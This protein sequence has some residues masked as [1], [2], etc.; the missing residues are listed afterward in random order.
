MGH[1]EANDP[2]EDHQ[3]QNVE[4]DCRSHAQESRH[5]EASPKGRGEIKIDDVKAVTRHTLALNRMPCNAGYST[6]NPSYKPVENGQVRVARQY[7]VV[8]IVTALLG[9][10][11]VVVTQVHAA[12]AKA[13]ARR[14][15]RQAAAYSAKVHAFDKRAVSVLARMPV[16]HGFAKATRSCNAA[17]GESSC[18]VSAANPRDALHEALAALK[19]IG[20]TL[21]R[22][23]C[24]SPATLAPRLR[25]EMGRSWLP[26]SAFGQLAG[27]EVSVVAFPAIDH[28]R[29]TS[30]NLVFGSTNISVELVRPLD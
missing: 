20:L 12:D 29:S 3:A 5:S 8:F 1:S 9:V 7:L 30:G 21:S 27:L 13:T 11:Y 15:A 6:L 24:D 16:P 23:G 22:N 4:D 2:I 28:S 26:C 19:P 17:P 18:F 10:A 14:D 25:A